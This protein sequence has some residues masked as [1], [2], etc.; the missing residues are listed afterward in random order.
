M[1]KRCARIT[2]SMISVSMLSAHAKGDPVVA[3][4][5]VL[6]QAYETI[7][8][9]AGALATSGASTLRSARSDARSLAFRVALTKKILALPT[10]ATTIQLDNSDADPDL[11]ER[12]LLCNI[13]QEHVKNVVGLNYLNTLVQKLNAV[14]KPAAAPTD[15]VEALKLLLATSSYSISDGVQS[16]A[17]N[18]SSLRAQI[19]TECQTDLKSYDKVYYGQDVG[20]TAPS[21]N[22]AT[23]AP[24]LDISL[25]FLGPIGTLID[26]FL[27]IVQPIFIDASTMVDEA[28]R[29]SVIESAL[30]DPAVRGKIKSVGKDLATEVD[31]YATASRRNAAGYFVEQLVSIREMPIDVSKHPECQGVASRPRLPS[32]A[33]S[34]AFIGC[35]KAVWGQLQPAVAGLTTA[36]ENYDTLADAGNVNAQKLFGTIM[37]DYELISA[38]KAEA[39][40]VFWDDVTQFITFANAITNAASKTNIARLQKDLT[41]ISK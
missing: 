14:S 25:A 12:V 37:A 29:R 35:W 15:I 38:G 11:G 41:A 26:T 24:G 20:G 40:N 19:V 31:K 9:S 2:F 8:A 27:S 7:I 13:R 16:K 32:G 22:E 34:A 23:A 18:V 30:K 17:E 4:T 33:P 39:T 1:W 36:G 3:P 21:V 5:I 10:G 28:R 6:P